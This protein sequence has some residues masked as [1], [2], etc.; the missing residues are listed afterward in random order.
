MEVRQ[1]CEFEVSES[2]FESVGNKKGLD[3][4]QF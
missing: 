3:L 4:N 1:E 2:R